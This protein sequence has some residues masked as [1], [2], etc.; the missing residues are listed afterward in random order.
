MG[1]IAG[2]LSNLMFQQVQSSQK[3]VNKHA[4]DYYR[5]PGDYIKQEGIFEVETDDLS[6]TEEIRKKLL[7]L[8]D[9]YVTNKIREDVIIALNNYLNENESDKIILSQTDYFVFKNQ[10]RTPPM[11]SIKNTQAEA[12]REKLKSALGENYKFTGYYVASCDLSKL[13]AHFS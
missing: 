3:T 9:L 4:F 11:L 10:S 1:N 13:W 7:D 8:P 6:Q 12:N 2:N 5:R